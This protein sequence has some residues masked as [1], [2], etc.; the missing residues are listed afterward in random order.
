MTEEVPPHTNSLV[1]PPDESE[2]KLTSYN[3]ILKWRETGWLESLGWDT[4][5]KQKSSGI[6]KLMFPA[7]LL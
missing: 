7:P 2:E 3:G 1:T 6:Q 4:Q 5:V